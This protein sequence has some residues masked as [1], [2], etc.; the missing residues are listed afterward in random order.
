MGLTNLQKLNL[1]RRDR[2]RLSLAKDEGER[3]KRLLQEILLYAKPQILQVETIE[4]NQLLADISFSL[5]KM[6]EAS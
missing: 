2:M 5:S 4:L 3:L 6:P 1:D